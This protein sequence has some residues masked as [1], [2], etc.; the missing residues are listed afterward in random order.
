MPL[1]GDVVN[2]VPVGDVVNATLIVAVL[3]P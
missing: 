3:I 1:D 2:L